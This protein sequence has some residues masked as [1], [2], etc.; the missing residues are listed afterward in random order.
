MSPF[1]YFACLIG[2]LGFALLTIGIALMHMPL[3]LIVA[4]V[5]LLA[6]SYLLAR[7]AAW[8]KNSQSSQKAS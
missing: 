6:W 7:C 2:L 5:V 8:Q 3:A 4:G 1:D